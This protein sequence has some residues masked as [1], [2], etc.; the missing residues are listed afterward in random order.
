MCWRCSRSTRI[1]CFGGCCREPRRASRAADRASGRWDEVMAGRRDLRAG[2]TGSVWR[3][4]PFRLSDERSAIPRAT[5][6]RRLRADRWC[7]LYFSDT[8][9]SRHRSSSSCAQRGNAHNGFNLLAGTPAAAAWTSNDPRTLKAL[10]RGTYGLS[11]ACSTPLAEG[12]RTKARIADWLAEAKRSRALV[13]GPRRPHARSGFRPPR[14]RRHASSGK[15][16]CRRRSLSAT[17]RH[18]QFD[19]S[20]HRRG[21]DARFVERSS[22]AGGLR[23]GQVSNTASASREARGLFRRRFLRKPVTDLALQYLA[24]FVLRQRGHEAVRPSAA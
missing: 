16:A 21:G 8:A 14:T 9:T 6:P 19:D 1:L 17:T 22:N 7:R 13:H 10:E 5:I 2:G 20:D 3:L 11:N 15:D 4:G 24:V 18:A 23:S 12:V